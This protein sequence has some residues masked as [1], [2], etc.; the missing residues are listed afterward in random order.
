MDDIS[1]RHN[2]LNN[3]WMPS[4]R[5]SHVI[6]IAGTKGYTNSMFHALYLVVTMEGILIEYGKM[7]NDGYK[8]D[9]IE[10]V[11]LEMEGY[12]RSVSDK[13]L[14][15]TKINDNIMKIIE[16][17][18]IELQPIYTEIKKQLYDDMAALRPILLLRKIKNKVK[19]FLGWG[20]D[21]NVNSRQNDSRRRQS[22]GQSC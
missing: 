8:C 19:R 14:D 11:I 13:V 1:L 7:R 2:Y 9:Y 12:I 21:E 18:A 4:A 17:R 3:V 10:P 5:V 20:N 22:D 15:N 6:S 16:D